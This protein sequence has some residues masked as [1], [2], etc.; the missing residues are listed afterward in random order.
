MAT[1]LPIYLVTLFLPNIN[2]TLHPT[3]LRPRRRDYIEH[4]RHSWVRS[5]GT[6]TPKPRQRRMPSLMQYN[7]NPHTKI[8]MYN[9]FFI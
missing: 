1:L 2:T 7:I 6:K 8:F 5:Q 4:Y 3:D 9:L